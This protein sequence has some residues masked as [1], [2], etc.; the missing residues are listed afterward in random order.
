[1]KNRIY[2]LSLKKNEEILLCLRFSIT[3]AHKLKTNALKKR[4][5]GNYSFFLYMPTS[6]SFTRHSENNGNISLK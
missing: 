5:M 4:N 6:V 2:S 3:Y 1:M